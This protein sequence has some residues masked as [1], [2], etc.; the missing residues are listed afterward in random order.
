MANLFEQPR[1]IAVEGPI[2]AGKSTLAQV[3]GETLHARRIA[4]GIRFID[5]FLAVATHEPV[6]TARVLLDYPDYL[7]GWACKS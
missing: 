7:A 5:Y 4:E 1:F 2:R 3:L 6:P